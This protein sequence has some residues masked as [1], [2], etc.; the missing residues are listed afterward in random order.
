MTAVLPRFAIRLPRDIRYDIVIF[1]VVVA[2]RDFRSRISLG[3]SL[4]K[5]FGNFQA[6]K[7]AHVTKSAPE[8]LNFRA[9]SNFAHSRE[10]V[11]FANILL[12]VACSGFIQVLQ[13]SAMQ[14]CQRYLH[15]AVPQMLCLSFSLLLP[16]SLSHTIAVPFPS[17]SL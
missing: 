3:P 12:F 2:T 6:K 9:G 7:M 15:N 14:P 16:F 1:F 4:R 10:L 8:P 5:Y 17:P 11:A 13:A